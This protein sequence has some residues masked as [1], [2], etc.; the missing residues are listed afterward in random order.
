LH[1]NTP[2]Q[3][4]AAQGG[5]LGWFNRGQMVK[6]FEDAAFSNK[7]NQITVVTTQF[8]IHWYKLLP[9]AKKP[10]RYRLLHLQEM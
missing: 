7:V 6:P 3:G 5:D 8:G 1:F 10:V 9:V 2:D 4:S